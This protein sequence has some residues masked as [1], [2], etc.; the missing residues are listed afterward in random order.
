MDT[1]DSHYEVDK[2]IALSNQ[3]QAVLGWDSKSFLARMEAR[4]VKVCIL[5][6]D[7]EPETKETPVANRENNGRS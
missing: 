3:E 5:K 7:M 6:G 1:A 2:S 4:F